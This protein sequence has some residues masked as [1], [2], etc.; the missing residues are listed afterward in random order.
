MSVTIALAGNPNCGKTTMFN[1][2]TGA[3]QYVGNW[4][5]VTVEKKEGKLKNQKDVTVTD[6]PGIYSLS[7]YTLEEVVSRDYLLKEKPDVIIDLVDATNIERNLYLAT[8]LLEIGIPVVIALNMVDLLKKNNI[9]INVKGLSSALGC[10]IVETSALKGTGLKEVVDEAIKCANQHRVPSKQMEFPKAVEKAVNEIEGF[11]PETI[12][13]ENRRWYA[14][15]LLE[16]DSKVKEGLSLP[17]SAQSRIEEIASNLEKAEDDDTESIVTDGRYQYIQKVVSANVKRSGNKMTVSDKIDRIVTNRVL[18][19]PIFIL[20]MFIVYYVSVTTVG[21][22]VTD[23]TNDSFV[24]SIQ[25]IVS[26]GLGNAGVADWLVSLV[27]DGI[28]GGLGAVLGFVPQMAILFLFLSILEDCGYMVRIAFVM[29]RVFRHFGLS[30]KSFIPLLISSGCGIPGIMA[31]KT[32]EADNDR[33]LTIMTATFIPC[34]AKLPVIALMGG[35][36]TAYATGDYVAAGF[37]TPLMYFIGVVAVL[38]S[39]IILKKTKPFSGKPAP[40]VMELPQYHIPSVKT[41]L[42]HVWERLKG[43]IIKAGTILFLAT[44]IMWI[45]SSI[46]NTGSGIGF[47]EDS[48]DSIMAILGG[49]LAPIFAPLGFGK[50][51]P[52]AASISGF[53]AKESIVS[54][55]GVLANVAGDDAEDTMIVGAAIK[56]WFPTAVAAF[57]FLLFNLLDSPCLAAI[58]T[59]AHEMQSRKWFWF[60]ILFQNIFAYVVTLCVYQIGLVVTGAGSFGIGTIVALIFVAIILFLLFRPDPYKNQNDVT[61]RSVQATE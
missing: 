44:V 27:S 33:R 45:L 31:S 4:P 58:S 1:A 40:F 13:Q 43:F 11:V 8:Q 30:G 2:L 52:V 57:S 21:T 36:M 5:G 24:G 3:N 15:K 7:P 56:A 32:I 42:L 61:R 6:L 55:M 51:Q 18:G 23:W 16:R 25:G 37:I 35:I 12:S 38:V 53:S 48:N 49:I 50:W 9:N 29:D 47:V 20:T 59:M 19:L 60:A 26:D 41:V 39:A 22:M 46:G 54:T 14:V 10:P 34:G 17:A 28:I